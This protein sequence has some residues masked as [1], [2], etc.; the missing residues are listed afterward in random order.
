[1]KLLEYQGKALFS[2]YG[3]Q[4]PS[5]KMIDSVE[6]ALS[7]AREFTQNVVVKAQV[8]VG[9]RG[10]AGGVKLASSSEDVVS[11]AEE[12]LGMDIRG[13]EAREIL[14]EEALDI[15]KEFYLS[16]IINNRNGNI[17]LMFSPLGGMD[18]EEIVRNNPKNLTRWEFD[19]I[20]VVREYQI[21]NCLRKSG[22][23]G[24]ILVKV[25]SLAR[26]LCTCFEKEDLTLAEINP[27]VVTKAGEIVAA[28]AKVEVDDNALFRHKEF[29]NVPVEIFDPYEKRAEEIGISYVHMEGN[30]G[31]IASG[32]GLAMNIMDILDSRGFTAANFLETGG[33]ITAK[34]ISDS[35]KLLFSNPKVKG[36]I[37]NLYGGVNPMIEAAR[38]VVDGLKANTRN[39]PLVVKLLGNQQEEAWGILEEKRIST[40]KTVHTEKAVDALLEKMEG[41]IVE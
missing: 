15:E 16:L 33:G 21:R 27:L 28:D 26:R 17:V 13:C 35:V 29:I 30:I 1:M 25:A 11:A 10:K 31:I 7:I 32:A 39:I 3:I 18:V 40:V 22:L 8:Y 19:D 20:S 6:D 9:G 41:R 38:G 5:G 24:E 23:Q 12:I 37:V 34:L 2:R 4:I 14:L 36:V